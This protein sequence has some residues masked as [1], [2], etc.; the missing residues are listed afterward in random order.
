L[1]DRTLAECE[2]A[3]Q[4]HL[5]VSM[6]A[7]K[8]MVLATLKRVPEARQAAEQGRTAYR[9]LEEARPGGYPQL[10]W[11]ILEMADVVVEL[12]AGRPDEAVRMLDA[13][14][15]KSLAAGS[16]ASTSVG[17]SAAAYLHLKVLRQPQEAIEAAVVALTAA[18]EL[19]CA[20]ADSS[21]RRSFAGLHE[22]VREWAIE[23]A[24]QLRD[25]RL[26]AE[27]LEV[28]RAQAIPYVSANGGTAGPLG[29]LLGAVLVAVETQAT[30]VAIEAAEPT[31]PGVEVPPPPFIVM[32]W[33]SIALARW[34]SYPPD[35][36]RCSGRVGLDPV[37]T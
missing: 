22:D 31:T 37:W 29:S 24:E 16:L 2:P 10:I 17:A 32:P 1:L 27:L 35:V 14:W 6:H 25:P 28:L 20:K 11:S 8:A 3:T 9:W 23:A 33:G 15:R 4:G 26:M 12:A 7:I 30:P 34:L 18:Q 19:E 36:E 21:D 13:N 5:I